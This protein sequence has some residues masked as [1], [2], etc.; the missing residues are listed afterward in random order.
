MVQINQ[1]SGSQTRIERVRPY[2]MAV[3]IL[4]SF[5]LVFTATGW[6][7][8]NGHRHDHNPEKQLKKLTERLGLT[9]AQQAKVKPLLEQKAQQLGALHQQMKDVRQKTRAQIE[10]ELTPEQISTFKEFREKRKAHKEAHKEKHGK[11]YKGKHKK[12]GQD[13]HEDDHHNDQDD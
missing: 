9:E 4:A 12:G 5:S 8:G 2:F 3:L 10:A 13:K 1:V 7:G 6:T 11:G